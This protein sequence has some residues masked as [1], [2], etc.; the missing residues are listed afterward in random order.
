MTGCQP[1]TVPLKEIKIPA[2]LTYP[3]QELQELQG[4]TGKQVL[5]WSLQVIHDYN[6]CKAKHKALVNAF[7]KDTSH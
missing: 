7:N 6:D 2:D 3:C 1:L 4:T 5:L